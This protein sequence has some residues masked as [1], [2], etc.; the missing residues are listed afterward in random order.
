MSPT[1]NSFYVHIIVFLVFCLMLIVVS[2]FLGGRHF[3]VRKESLFQSFSIQVKT[4]YFAEHFLCPR[5]RTRHY[6]RDIKM[7]I[8]IVNS[9][10][11]TVCKT[12]ARAFHMLTTSSWQILQGLWYSRAYHFVEN[13]ITWGS[14]IISL[15]QI[16]YLK[17]WERS[18]IF[19]IIY[20][21]Y[22]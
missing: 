9:W 14:I 22:V 11:H 21:L 1:R 20:I 19:C 13:S 17:A 5:Q 8:M 12:L 4:M 3:F 2:L 18:A 16:A 15:T 10:V 7:V 6:A